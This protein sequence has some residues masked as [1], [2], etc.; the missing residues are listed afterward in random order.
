ML[1]S[2]STEKDGDQR[3]NDQESLKDEGV[4]SDAEVSDLIKSFGKNPYNAPFDRLSVS[5]CLILA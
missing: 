3:Q 4:N 5:S 1:S 2:Y